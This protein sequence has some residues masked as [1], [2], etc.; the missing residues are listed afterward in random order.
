[1][2]I[3]PHKTSSPA[4]GPFSG[5]ISSGATALLVALVLT[6]APATT[7]GAGPTPTPET[8]TSP[9]PAVGTPAISVTYTGNE[10]FLIAVAGHKILIDAL[11]HEGVSGYVFPSPA[12]RTKMESGLAPFEGVNLALATHYHADHFHPEAVG[13][14]L[15]NN[16]TATF[17]STEQGLKALSN[18]FPGFEEIKDRARGLTPAEGAV[19]QEKV[20]DLDIQI[21]NLHHGRKRS[22]DNIGFLIRAGG[23]TILHMGDTEATATD[24]SPFGLANKKIDLAFVPF[25][26][27]LT[28][29]WQ[30]AIRKQV[31]PERIVVMHLPAPDAGDKYIN[32]LGGWDKVATDI[33]TAFP[34]AT[35]FRKQMESARF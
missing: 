13:T 29:G 19:A 28:D 11:Y 33:K 5:W 17:I 12:Q 34:N 35:I 22:V 2:K 23:R 24:L 21:F 7:W 8:E 26:Y 10:G 15:T 20:G 6:L 30:R 14:F 27:L 18:T 32:S 9:E 1:M 4:T 3:V 31:A 16:P 25:W